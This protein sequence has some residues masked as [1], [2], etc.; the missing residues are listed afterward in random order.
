MTGRLS[1]GLP[2]GWAFA[3]SVNATALYRT[4]LFELAAMKRQGIAR[5]GSWHR[6]DVVELV[7]HGAPTL[8][9][10]APVRG[11]CELTIGGIRL[12][13]APSAGVQPP[14][15]TPIIDDEIYPIDEIASAMGWQ[16][17]TVRGLISGALKKKLGLHVVS[18]GTDRGRLYR[19]SEARSAGE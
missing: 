10:D 13:L 12:R 14:E 8:L 19:I 16:R 4:P 6:G 5:L 9:V 15:L 1:S 11:A 3:T 18:K 17:H 7:V 2:I